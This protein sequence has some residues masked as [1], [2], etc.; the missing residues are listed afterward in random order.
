MHAMTYYSI[1]ISNL[2]PTV[3]STGEFIDCRGPCPPL[4]HVR[5]EATSQCTIA[6]VG[7]FCRQ[8]KH[9]CGGLCFNLGKMG[10]SESSGAASTYI[11]GLIFLL[12]AGI[13][14]VLFIYMMNKRYFMCIPHICHR[15]HRRCLCK[16]F[17]P[18]VIFFQIE[19][20]KLAFYCI[21]YN[22]LRPSV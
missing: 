17:L 4:S 10:K 13:A 5:F 20:E 18:G 19:R 3:T 14:V 2:C 1:P 9:I 21:V 11:Y 7:G 16:Y 6:V 8:R 15:H 22:N 12:Y